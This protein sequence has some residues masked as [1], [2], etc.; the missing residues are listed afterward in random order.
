MYTRLALNRW[1]AEDD[2][3]L[4]TLLLTSTFLC[5]FPWVLSDVDAGGVKSKA[6]CK[7]R[8]AS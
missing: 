2:L 8:Q 4:L 7:D 3:E 1:V 6:L 5:Y